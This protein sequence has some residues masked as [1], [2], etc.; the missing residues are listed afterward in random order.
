MIIQVYRIFDV[1]THEILADGIE[2]YTFALET[3]ELYRRDYPHS[4]I[5]MESY[6]RNTV[7]HGF[8][9]DPDLHT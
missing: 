4:V 2:D 1:A 6:N 7:K 8:G 5:E 3:L 9:R